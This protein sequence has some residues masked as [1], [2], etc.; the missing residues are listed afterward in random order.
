MTIA[1]LA[2]LVGLVLTAYG[3]WVGG[4]ARASRHADRADLRMVR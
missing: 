1:I 4:I 3:L 2:G